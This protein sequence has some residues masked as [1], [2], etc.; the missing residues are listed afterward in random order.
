M[1]YKKIVLDNGL[2]VMLVPNKNTQAVTVLV[3]VGAGSKYETKQNNGISHFVEHMFF[4][5]TN[6]RPNTLAISETLDRVGGFYN[7]FT[8]KEYTGYFAKVDSKHSDLALD[9]VSDIFLN[10]KIDSHEIEKER[11]VISEE[12]NMYLDTPVRHIRDLFETLLYGD[13]PAGW[14]I[15]GTKESIKKI[16]RKDFIDYIKNHYSASNTIVCV[17]GNFSQEKMAQD[18]KRKFKTINKEQPQTKEKVIEK[19]SCPQVHLKFKETDQTHFCLGVR[20]FDLF[21]PKVYIQE[22]LATILGGNMSS[23]LFI[24]VREKNGLAYYIKTEAEGFTDSGYLVTQAGIPHS[25]LPKAVEMILKEYK[26]LAQKTITEQELKK[27][28]D[29]LKGNLVLSLESSDALASFYAGQELLT[30]RI[31]TLQEECAKIDKVKASEV[32]ALAKEI[33]QKQ[34]LSLAV[35]GPHKNEESL[36]KLMIL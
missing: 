28:K 31:L 8:S 9:W 1:D 27:A 20:A 24:K 16:Q 29:Y 3:V 19:Q 23:R 32:K 25:A 13:Q 35:I 30:N 18:I 21:S 12:L 2:R 15:V 33:F 36:K 5:G 4:K 10:S 7:A 6:K 22:V 17:S 14:E 11:G 34:S 26:N